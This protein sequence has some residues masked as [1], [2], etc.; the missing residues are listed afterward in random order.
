MTP[1]W[2][3]FRQ[4][5]PGLK[6]TSSLSISPLQLRS[7]PSSAAADAFSLSHLSI[8]SPNPTKILT[9]IHWNLEGLFLGRS[10]TISINPFAVSPPGFTDQ[11]NSSFFHFFAPIYDSRCCLVN[12]FEEKACM[13]IWNTCLK[14]FSL[15]CRHLLKNCVVCSCPAE[16]F[17]WTVELLKR[18]QS[19]GT[20][21]WYNY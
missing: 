17:I 8:P 20:Q 11:G 14:G 10:Y 13:C 6:P 2:T 21:M 12:P 16:L 19:S 4:G 9:E 7:F 3:G 1:G 5:Q 15:C 18:P